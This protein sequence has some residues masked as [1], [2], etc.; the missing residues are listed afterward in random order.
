[1]PTKPNPETQSI[2][3]ERR[4]R[5]IVSL[6]KNQGPLEAK[7]IAAEISDVSIHATNHY[8]NELLMARNI[9]KV[10][11]PGKPKNIKAYEYWSDYGSK[12]DMVSAA[13]SNP[14]HRVIASIVKKRN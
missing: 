1:M 8:L 4:L 7:A 3:K 10:Q 5:E 14:L 11:S 9:R 13:L 2:L 6:L 12:S